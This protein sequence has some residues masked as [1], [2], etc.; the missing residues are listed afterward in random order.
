MKDKWGRS[1]PED[2]EL[3]APGSGQ[4]LTF[5][6]KKRRKRDGG[7]RCQRRVPLEAICRANREGWNWAFPTYLTL[8]TFEDMRG[9]WFRLKRDVREAIG[10]PQRTRHRHLMKLESLGLIEL[11]QPTNSTY[12]VKVI[13]LDA[14]LRSQ[15]HEVTT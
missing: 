14:W 7:L 12:E 6:P 3:Q 15:A 9:V 1:E 2:P 11:R 5:G 10:L 4:V 8:A 13:N